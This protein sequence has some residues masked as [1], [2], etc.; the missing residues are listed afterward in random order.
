MIRINLLPVRAA[1]KKESVRFQLTLAGLITFMVLVISFAVYFSARSEAS[2]VSSELKSGQDELVQLKRKIG[3]L[4][5]IKAQKKVVEDKL[6][7]IKKL[8]VERT[9]PA[10]LFNMIS[11]SIPEKAW[12]ESFVDQGP[13]VTLRGYAASDEVVADFM[14]RLQ[15]NKRLRGVELEVVRSE[16]D[17][18]TNI[19]IVSFVIRLEKG[20]S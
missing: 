9:G 8:E 10:E 13:K 4:S 20:G 14:R 7:V 19:E 11:G 2:Y 1:K 15:R 12:L 6:A 5:K 16:V 17:Q 18:Q 3:E